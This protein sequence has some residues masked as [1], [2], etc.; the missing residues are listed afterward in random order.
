MNKVIIT[1]NSSRY[2]FL[3]KGNLIRSLIENGF[4]VTVISPRDEYAERF[5]EI[6]AAYCP[7]KMDTNGLNPFKDLVLLINMFKIYAEI[8]PDSNLLFTIKP[9]I[10]G[11][12]ASSLLGIK[13]INN[14]TATKYINILNIF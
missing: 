2:I 8:R 4:S 14:I 6:G 10:Y 13:T 12:L 3:F 1:N 7:I 11:T 5:H 9:N